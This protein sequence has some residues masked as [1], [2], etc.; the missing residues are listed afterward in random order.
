MRPKKIQAT[1]PST[2]KRVSGTDVGVTKT[3]STPEPTTTAQ[4]PIIEQVPTREDAPNVLLGII[5]IW[6]PNTVVLQ[7]IYA[8]N[9]CNSGKDWH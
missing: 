6:L 5:G 3:A 2:N 9:I 1:G 7:L 8:L 4:K